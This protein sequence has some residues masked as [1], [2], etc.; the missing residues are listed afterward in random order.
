MAL[1]MTENGT[2]LNG[3]PY[4]YIPLPT[5]TSIRVLQ[6][7]PRTPDGRV[8]ISLKT[9]DLINYPFYHA[10]SYTWGNPHASGI[11]FNE[12]FNNVAA[13]YSAT[14]RIPIICDGKLL[15]VQQN[16]HD[17]L[18]QLPKR[19]WANRVEQQ[20][21]KPTSKDWF[22][23][24]AGGS[25]DKMQSILGDGIDVNAVD[26]MGRTAL[27]YVC[28]RADVEAVRLLCQ[29]GADVTIRDK[30]GLTPMDYASKGASTTGG[31]SYVNIAVSEVL[32]T[33]WL[34][35]TS[36][37][38]NFIW[39]DALCINQEDFAER[40][41][42]VRIMDLIYQKALY[43]V[44]WFG[45]E[46]QFTKGAVKTISKIAAYPRDVFV[47]SDIIPYR[48]QGPQVYEKSKLPY[49]TW[50]EWCSLAAFLKRQW[51][52]RLWIVQESILSRRLI[53][54]CG[55]Y[56]ISWDELCDAAKNLQ[57]RCKAFGSQTSTIFIAI[58]EIA[59]SLESNL[60]SLRLWRDNHH[61][62]EDFTVEN[63][64]F[65]N[66]LY[67]TW[68]FVTTDPRDKVYGLFGLVAI[69]KGSTWE[70]DYESSVEE[71]FAEVTRRVIQ[72][73]SSLKILS[74][75]QGESHRKIRIYPSWL[76]DYSLPYFNMMST[77]Y[78]AAGSNSRAELLP[79]ARWDRLRLRIAI[80]DE[81][82]EIGN[83]RTEYVNSMMLL[84]PSWFELAM[85]LKQPYVTGQS[86]TEVLWR[87]LC[88]DQDSNSNSP[89]PDR[90]G[91]LFK[92]FV[93]AMVVVRAELEADELATGR[94]TDPN[95]SASLAA[96]L[97]YTR[98]FWTDSNMGTAPVDHLLA[99]FSK[100]PRFMS[101]PE[102]GWLIYTL[103]KLE[104]LSATEEDPCVPNMAAL[105]KF[106][107]TPSYVMR[108]S[109]K[110]LLGPND[111]GFV[112]SFRQRYGKRKLFYTN[113]GY[114]GL[115]PSAAQVGDVVC[116]MPGAGGPFVF[117]QYDGPDVVEL[118]DGEG[119][120]KDGIE[121]LQVIGE[122]Y[123][124]GIMHGEATKAEG[125]ELK[126][127]EIL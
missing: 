71:C 33:E 108:D 7:H 27:H 3:E 124:H 97:E 103:F 106:H 58:D 119:K 23:A 36:N 44:I 87:T 42:Q 37:P 95:C 121:R 2:S 41:A 107:E 22:D 75:I 31:G 63:F 94:L 30:D 43:T 125:F 116:I 53:L 104:I 18:C 111:A 50:I 122:S 46:D 102:Q 89:A 70:V 49:T 45:R 79:S 62:G 114:L 90:F 8:S 69:S 85:L 127:V 51:F 26:G 55:E 117:R 126:E 76:P 99:E 54:F 32:A 17:A 64:S 35:T 118:R 81:I 47:S 74:C 93:S 40:G 1:N 5:L 39:I 67:D 38:D 120:W 14:K 100:R 15:H 48:D 9:V 109:D 84:E 24:V 12:H 66:L 65:E 86:R 115:G 98:R 60:L 112:D 10:L 61:K 56:E 16:L 28:V 96:A 29:A 105:E 78:D 20:G 73:T 91:A 68:T 72:E 110:T 6:I 123:V 77:L 82:A 80:F 11:D 13:E 34:N 113:S 83:D 57:A 21:M 25:P 4:R 52:S 92:E 101:R 19:T 59:L 88:A